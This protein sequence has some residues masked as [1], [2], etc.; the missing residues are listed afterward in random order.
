M[1]TVSSLKDTLPNKKQLNIGFKGSKQDIRTNILTENEKKYLL[2]R[3][4]KQAALH[5]PDVEKHRNNY[6]KQLCITMLTEGYH[7]SFVELE[8]ILKLQN[9]IRNNLGSEHPVWNKTL[10]DQEPHKLDFLCAHL[11]EAENAERNS[12]LSELYGWYNSLANYFLAS[13]DSWLSDY[14]FKKCLSSVTRKDGTLLDEQK[15]AESQ[16]NLGLAYERQKSYFKALDHFEAYYKLCKNKTWANSSEEIKEI[17]EGNVKFYKNNR[18]QTDSCV[19]LQR[20]YKV[21]AAKYAK[22][23]NEKINYLQRVYDVSKESGIKVLEGVA[24]FILGSCY[25]DN[26]DLETALKCF[27]TFFEITNEQ[28]DLENFGIASEALANCYEKMGKIEKSIEYFQKYLKELSTSEANKGY[29]R[30]CSCLANIYNSLGKYEIASDYS[31]KAFIM[32]SKLNDNNAIELNRVISGISNAHK[33]L[34]KFN[35]SIEANNK[36]TTRSLVSWKTHYGDF[37]E[38]KPEEVKDK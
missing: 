19:H 38:Y 11:N 23:N 3:H 17:T 8:K 18:L 15:A 33:L 1:T 21:L 7:K 6:K 32:S 5:R 28:N 29:A 22:D 2:L 20:I 12:N 36:E 9:E 31:N 30:A 26:G 35:Q 37:N 14:F 25:K 24:C 4:Q 13:D 10:L 16:C 34:K 27:T